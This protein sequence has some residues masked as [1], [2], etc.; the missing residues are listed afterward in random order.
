MA[1]FTEE[2]KDARIARARR[3]AELDLLVSGTYIQLNGKPKGCSVGCDAIDIQLAAGV[4]LKDLTSNDCHRVVAEHDGTPEWLEHL[5]DAVFEGLPDEDRHWW[6]VKLAES[7]PVTSDWQ[8]YYHRICI[9]ILTLCLEHKGCWQDPYATQV[10]DAIE[11]TISYHTNP[12]DEA[13]SSARF[14]AESAAEAA[15]SAA[16]AARSAAWAARSAAW[17][18]KS[19]AWSTWSAAESAAEAACSAWSAWSAR[20]A[21]CKRIAEEIIDVFKEFVGSDRGTFGMAHQKPLP[22]DD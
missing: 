19:A 1:T 12:S 16:W 11:L 3:H 13:K 5:R 21:A 14:A 18:T 17:A 8:P 7:L 9:R 15:R 2:K 4:D 6:H 22:R 10:I 20:S